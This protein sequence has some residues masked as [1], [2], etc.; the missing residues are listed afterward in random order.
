MG[1]ILKIHRQPQYIEIEGR[2]YPSDIRI[3]PYSASNSEHVV[4]VMAY[5]AMELHYYH[6][7]YANCSLYYHYRYEGSKC[8]LKLSP[9]QLIDC[10]SLFMKTYHSTKQYILT[11]NMVCFLR[12]CIVHPTTDS[13]YDVDMFIQFWTTN[14][15]TIEKTTY[16]SYFS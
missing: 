10:I 11:P 16:I 2:R 3:I 1:N 13:D 14:R 5:I 8:L 4:I 6:K 7:I 9:V 12:M 15:E